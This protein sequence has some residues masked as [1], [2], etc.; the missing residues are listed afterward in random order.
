MVKKCVTVI[1][2]TYNRGYIIEKTIPSYIQDNVKE[3][4]VVDDASKDDTF[5]VMKNL[6][7]KYP[8][9][10]YIRQSKNTG[11]T[12]AKNRGI[13]EVV[14]DYIYF[15]DDDSFILPNTIK[16]LLETMEKKKAD[17]VGA[18]PLYMD[19]EDDFKDIS[20]FIKNK[21]RILNEVDEMI[22]LYHL[23][24]T[25]FFYR[26]K[27]PVE[28]PFTAACALIKSNIAKKNKFDNRFKGNAY[29]EETDYFLGCNELG[30]K[31]WFDSRAVQINYPFSSIK[32]IRTFKSMYRHAYYDLI[33]TIKLINKHHWFFVEKYNYKYSKKRMIIEYVIND[34]MMYISLLPNRLYSI[35]KR[36]LIVK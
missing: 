32:R 23:E 19:G 9:I 28:V 4:I 2:P 12:G 36:K 27:H 7:K 18:M 17:I 24:T 6:T 26:F 14:T 20:L 22:N 11:Q 5:Q 16:Y 13:L 29:R 8:I 31:I 30:A 25:C 3:V 33:N 15:G 10:K 1:I 34:I 21:A 35:L